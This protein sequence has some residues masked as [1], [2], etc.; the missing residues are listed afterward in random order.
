MP[1]EV[2]VKDKCGKCGTKVSPGYD[3]CLSCGVKFSEIPPT[4]RV[5]DSATT[6]FDN[7]V[8]LL[9]FIGIIIAI[10]SSI[11]GVIIFG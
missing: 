1:E 7:L 4:Y 9:W 3:F 5:H 8:P 6:A 2:K 11:M 10:I